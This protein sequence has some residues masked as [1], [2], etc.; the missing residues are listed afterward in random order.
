LPH[1]DL[2]LTMAEVAVAFAGF[3]SLVGLLGQRASRDDPR[4]LGARMRGMIFF[5]L[6]AVAFSMLP[7]ILDSYGLTEAVVWR[8]ASLLLLA[9]FVGIAW[10]LALT[11]RALR[12]SV[13]QRRTIV[14]LIAVVLYGSIG[15]GIG[16][17]LANALGLAS[18]LAAAIYLT[19]LGLLLFLAG[20]AFL[21]IVFSFLPGLRED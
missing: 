21:L 11:I 1:A 4:V 12:R 14:R 10:W 15:A 7:L 6:A 3:A 13:G 8:T 19:A 5:S 2:L 16:V 20:F 17:A 18:P 9:A